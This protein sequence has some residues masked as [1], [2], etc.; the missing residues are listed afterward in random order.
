MSDH[1]HDPLQEVEALLGAYLAKR[2]GQIEAR[3]GLARVQAALGQPVVRARGPV[4]RFKP[5]GLIAGFAAAVALATLGGVQLGPIQASPLDLVQE[6]KRVHNQ[7]LERC[8]VANIERVV[9]EDGSESLP[10]NIRQ[11]RVW[12]RG[13][14]FW[15]EMQPAHKDSPIIWGREQDGS[16]WTVLDDHRGVRI[17]G[18]QVPRLLAT[19]AD[20]LSLNVDTLLNDV[21]HNCVLVEDA[22]MQTSKWTRTIRALPQTLRSRLWLEEADLEI[23]TEARVLRHLTLH[24]NRRGTPYAKLTFTLIETR[25]ARDA[26]YR[27]EDRLTE[28]R[29][30]YERPIGPAIR[31]ELFA[32]WMPP[33]ISARPGSRPGS[34]PASQSIGSSQSRR[35]LRV[36][37]ID[38][39]V[40]TPLATANK[41]ASLLLFVLPDCPVC[42]AYAPEIKR[43]CNDY[44]PR[45]V[46]VFIVHADPDVTVEEARKHA[47]DYQLSCPVLLDPV[48]TLVKRAGA[49]MAPEAALLNS[50]GTV[51]YLGRIDDLFADYGK[52]RV[53]ST[54]HDLRNALDAV[55]AGKFVP[56]PLAKP[57]GCHI[58]PLGK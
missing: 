27:L 30:I 54:Q 45:G 38:G 40:Y 21:L 5:A 23:D 51:V 19:I 42:N 28:P 20:I 4:L 55:L 24:R 18:D 13:D 47:R 16:I 41:K 26:S 12:T 14:R 15:V 52:K 50:D 57:I 36:K 32:R 53:Q 33:Q 44:E 25:P 39:K 17:P 11:A 43:L 37:A 8:Y 2:A 48:H 9:S 58:P 1:E 29:H 31:R 6:V 10:G 56:A 3:A 34:S 35:D 22:G 7:A 49:K 46:N